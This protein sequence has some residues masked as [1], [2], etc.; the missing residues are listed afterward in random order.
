MENRLIKQ[1]N[2]LQRSFGFWQTTSLVVGTVIGSG[3]FFK[4]GRVIAEAGDSKTALWAWAVSGIIA[5][6]GALTIAELSS[7]IP[8]T[9]GLYNYIAAVYG[10]FWAYVTGW[11]QVV[12]YGPALIATLG[13]F[14]SKLFINLLGIKTESI[15]GISLSVWITISIIIFLTIINLFENKIAGYFNITTTLIKLI[16]VGLLAAY[17][18]IFGNSD[19]LEQTV[20]AVSPSASGSGFGVAMLSALFAYDGWIIISAVSGE[21]KKPNRT[22]PKALTVGMIFVLIVYVLVTFGIIKTLPIDR[23]VE[24]DSDAPFYIAKSAFGEVGG[25]LISIT[26]LISIIGTLNSKILTFPRIAYEMA[27]D[28]N[29]IFPKTLRKVGMYSR[30]PYNSV[31]MISVLAIILILF[32]GTYDVSDWAILITWVLY[33][34]AFIGLFILRAR[35]KGEESA[36]KVP[37]YPY[38][39]IVAIFGAVFIISSTLMSAIANFQNGQPANLIGILISFGIVMLGA[40]VY[41]FLNIEN[42]KPQK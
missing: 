11:T 33:L 1:D 17:G 16:P 19:A 28:D 25:R 32:A 14:F 6:A 26:I 22:L 20:S 31:L 42:K 12:F 40:P 35:E 29:S 37:L 41:M 4:Q 24:L 30:I 7:R 36:Y 15:F 38:I 5:L 27:V 9:G 3:I 2:K 10:K 39:P 13:Y 18:L 23:L 8:K 21:V 34:M